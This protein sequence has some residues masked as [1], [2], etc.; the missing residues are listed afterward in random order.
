M[1]LI[2]LTNVPKALH[3]WIKTLAASQQKAIGD[4][5]IEFLE[6]NLPKQIQAPAAAERALELTHNESWQSTVRR[7]AQADAGDAATRNVRDT[8]R[9]KITPKRP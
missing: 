7:S 1:G 4:Y 6:N 8:G 2:R 5:L 9:K 3:A